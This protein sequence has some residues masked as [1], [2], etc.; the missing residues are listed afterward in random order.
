MVD[1]LLYNKS[2]VQKS[3]LSHRD[4]IGVMKKVL[5]EFVDKGVPVSVDQ[6]DFIRSRVLKKIEEDQVELEHRK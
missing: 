1:T 5:S 2:F 6:D 4:F 3:Y